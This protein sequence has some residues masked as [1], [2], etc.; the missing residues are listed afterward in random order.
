[1]SRS[2]ATA[3]GLRLA[4]LKTLLNEH[5]HAYHVLDSPTISDSEYDALFQELLDLEKNNPEL[6]SE[7]SPSRRVGG[8]PLEAFDQ[9]EHRVA[10]LSLENAFDHD[11]ILAFE[12]RLHR[13]LNSSA[14]LQYV[15]EPKL[16]GLAVELIYDNGTLVQALTRGD[17]KV[18]ENVSE[19]VRTIGAIPLK[20]R[21]TVPS[22]LEVR[23]EVFINREGF[24]ALNRQRRERGEA[25]FANARNAAAGSL[26]QLDPRV[27]AQRPLRFFAYGVSAT[28]NVDAAGQYALLDFLRQ[29]G[30]PV[31]P[32]TRLCP[33]IE[34]VIDTYAGFLARRHELDYDIDGMVVKVDDFV[35]Q[36]RLGFKARAPRWAVA[37][38]FPA[39]QATTTLI[40]ITHQ[41]GRTGAITPVAVL[42]PVTVDGA[43]I[44]RATLHNQEEIERKDLRI[45]D[46][47]LIQRAGDVIPEVIKPIAAKRTGAEKTIAEPTACPVCHH[48]LHKKEGETITRCRNTLCPAQKLRALIH[49]T[50]KAGLDIEGLGKKYIEQLFTHGLVSDIPDIF[51]L[52]SKKLAELEGWGEK[53]AAKVVGAIAAKKHPSLAA[54]LAALGIRFIG[55]VTASLLE[56][57]FTTLGALTGASVEELLEI[58]GIGGQTAHSLYEYFR[59]PRTAK[60]LLRL[61]ELGVSPAR[62][63][64]S[65]GG[66]L[67][68]KSFLF[69]GTLHSLSRNEAKA[70]V[71][72]HGGDIATTVSTKLTHVVAGDNPGSKLEKARKHDK[73]ILDEEDFLALLT[74]AKQSAT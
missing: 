52:N 7:D 58:E 25:L 3:D 4:E 48:Q 50:S 14:S 40:D 54:L 23:G 60:L 11:D 5:A 30:L 18:G 71:K 12:K 19:Q 17:G 62:K 67:Q 31:N 72:E 15:A 13:F 10:M 2:N 74:L 47:V 34:D 36:Q 6:V 61:E 64:I 39:T 66:G 45:G 44:S 59:E 20:L 49:F 24:R 22:I 33:T 46:T 42:A 21:R 57:R 68:G 27:T 35:L 63:K 65:A 26:R 16:D 37:C 38:K 29:C 9:A 69:T 53:S 32:L 70:R 1:M 56:Q 43:V 41:V 55:E 51:T 73:E 28:A 8:A